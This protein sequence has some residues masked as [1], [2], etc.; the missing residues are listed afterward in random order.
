M[1]IGLKS[2]ETMSKNIYFMKMKCIYIK[3]I[4][5]AICYLYAYMVEHTKYNILYILKSN[6]LYCKNRKIYFK[7]NTY[8]HKMKSQ[9]EFCDFRFSFMFMLCM[10]LPFSLITAK[11]L[12]FY[13]H[14]GFLI[15]LIIQTIFSCYM[16]FVLDDNASEYF[17]IFYRI[18]ILKK[19]RSFIWSLLI[20]EILAWM[21]CIYIFI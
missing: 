1:K 5:Y 16:M 2:V 9:I 7:S 11:C 8:K 6:N 13:F 19:K 15:W 12:S 21:I 10:I 20:L 18:N 3:I 14:N 4:N 17:S